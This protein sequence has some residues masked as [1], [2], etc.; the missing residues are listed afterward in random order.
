MAKLA[1][2]FLALA[3][4]AAPAATADVSESTPAGSVVVVTGID[5]PCTPELLPGQCLVDYRDNGTLTPGDDE[6]RAN[7]A[8][9]FSVQSPY[10]PSSIAVRPGDSVASDPILEGWNRTSSSLPTHSLTAPF[11][12]V[13]FGDRQF[14][15]H[16]PLDGGAADRFYYPDGMNASGLWIPRT[17]PL[18]ADE[19]SDQIVGLAPGAFNCGFTATLP[20]LSSQ[21]APMREATG[22]VVT[23]WDE[24]T[25]NVV[26][27]A[28]F[29]G[30]AGNA[31]LARPEE[32]R[33]SAAL[34]S[35]P[36]LLRDEM[37][38]DPFLDSDSPVQGDPSLPTSS[39]RFN[40]APE[41]VAAPT[42]GEAHTAALQAKT[43]RGTP[44]GVI[45]AVGAACGLLLA[46]VLVGLFSRLTRGDVFAQ[47]TRARVLAAVEQAPAGATLADLVR[48]TGLDRT[49]ASYHLRVLV[50]H[51]AVARV[52][53]GSLTLYALPHV[54]GKIRA[55]GVKHIALK[56]AG[57]RR[58]L[59]V[60]ARAHAAGESLTLEEV[61][62]RTQ[63]VAR[64]TAWRQLSRLE[65][66]GIVHARHIPGAKALHYE[67]AG[68]QFDEIAAL[69]AG[70][71]PTASAGAGERRVGVG[72]VAS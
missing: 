46:L 68:E 12:D 18:T 52:D 36:R 21:C 3:F 25:P 57:T 43:Q 63:V 10:V 59:M 32:A 53:A 49:T 30:V 70:A 28:H 9:G 1:L 13:G 62:E 22:F 47:E 54:A 37:V 4:L 33:K 60:L 44:L 64:S 23:A 72:G 31:P 41:T 56:S 45:L 67:I 39:T 38:A 61:V 17:F 27:G 42:Q 55:A 65:R 35:H 48:L 71:E 66:D 6:V 14:F 11:A 5:A 50:G 16:H 40:G 34:D 19:T 69:L 20:N 26:H 29:G 15:V 58:V 2:V 7:P 8:V 51:S 24:T